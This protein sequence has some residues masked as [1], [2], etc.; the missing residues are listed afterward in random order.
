MRS[1][2]KRFGFVIRSLNSSKF[3]PNFFSLRKMSVVLCQPTLSY[4]DI[5]LK[6]EYLRASSVFAL[7]LYTIP[8]KVG[9][10]DLDPAS[11]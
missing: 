6:C 5:Y 8:G 10:P 2:G 1:H 9:V 4:L 11:G 3:C 7:C